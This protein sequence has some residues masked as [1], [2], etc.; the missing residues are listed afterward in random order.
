VWSVGAGIS[1]VY[2]T[3]QTQLTTSSKLPLSAAC[4]VMSVDSFSAPPF[5]S[6]GGTK[7]VIV[8]DRRHRCFARRRLA[9]GLPAK[10]CAAGLPSISAT[11]GRTPRENDRPTRCEVVPGYSQVA[12]A[13]AHSDAF[14][15]ARNTFQAVAICS[16]ES[17]L[18]CR[19]TTRG[20]ALSG[21]RLVALTQLPFLRAL[22]GFFAA[23]L[24]TH[25]F[26][27]QTLNRE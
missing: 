12:S 25:K 24:I 16:K 15:S 17:N 10:P 21:S 9:V 18:R 11:R 2:C 5:T 3:Q 7:R 19:E 14:A 4:C 22:P 1:G 6:E 27:Y 23:V 20:L 13:R 8:S 26:G